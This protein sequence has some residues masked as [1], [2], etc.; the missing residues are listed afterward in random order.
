VMGDD[1]IDAAILTQPFLNQLVSTGKMVGATT[2]QLARVPI[3]VAVRQGTPK[4]DISSVEAF[5]R[6]LLDAKF[7]TYGDPGMGDAAGV[8][9]AR[10]WKHSAFLAR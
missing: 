2:A 4:P 10:L 1:P 8:H 7:V 9:V 3:G 6:A 5:K